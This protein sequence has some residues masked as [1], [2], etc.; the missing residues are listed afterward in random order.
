MYVTHPAGGTQL[1]AVAVGVV[2]VA[3]GVGDDASGSAVAL[4]GVAEGVA[5]AV[6]LEEGLEVA[7]DAWPRVPSACAGVVGG[8]VVGDG[9]G[10]GSSPRTTSG[11]SDVGASATG[12]CTISLSLPPPKALNTSI[13]SSPT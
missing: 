3:L 11:C 8:G 6:G 4:V 9:V 7:V 13:L 1:V 10:V 2:S 12:F 5:V